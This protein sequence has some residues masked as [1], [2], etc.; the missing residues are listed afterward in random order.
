[1][2]FSSVLLVLEI[3]PELNSYILKRRLPLKGAT[4]RKLD[5]P[6]HTLQVSEAKEGATTLD[7]TLPSSE[8]MNRWLEAL[9][10]C[11]RVTLHESCNTISPTVP[12]QYGIGHVLQ[13]QQFSC[14]A[15]ELPTAYLIL[16]LYRPTF[17][18]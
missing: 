1:V 13:V 12:S 16:L 4:V 14:I 9:T 6:H 15:S 8:E 3:T 18:H 2:A 7:M 17:R 11:E 10:L 5:T